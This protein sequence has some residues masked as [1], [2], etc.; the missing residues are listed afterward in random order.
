MIYVNLT[1]NLRSGINH[2]IF[3]QIWPLIVCNNGDLD[4]LLSSTDLNTPGWLLLHGLKIK[5]KSSR[6]EQK[7]QEAA[8]KQKTVALLS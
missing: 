1:L 6:D 5:L 8:L 4:P 2:W 7:S 3:E